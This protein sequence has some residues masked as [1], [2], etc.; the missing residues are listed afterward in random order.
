VDDGGLGG[1]EP[2][3]DEAMKI[4]LQIQ[5]TTGA[6][7]WEHDTEMAGSESMAI[8]Y[9][10]RHAKAFNG[11]NWFMAMLVWRM[12]EEPM[13]LATIRLQE[14]DVRITIERHTPIKREENPR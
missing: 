11:V 12:E 13:L 9:G 3:E 5:T 14:P 6:L 1:R 4:K 8:E 10:A 2:A 7:P